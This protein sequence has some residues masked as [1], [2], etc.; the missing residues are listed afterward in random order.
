MI[1]LGWFEVWSEVTLKSD[2]EGSRRNPP[3]IRAPNGVVADGL[4]YWG[5]NNIPW[6]PAKITVPVL[7]VKGEW[8]VDTPA[9]MAQ[10]LFP[11]LTGAPYKRYVEIGEGT[12]TLIM[13]KNRMALFETVQQ[14]FD[15]RYRPG[16]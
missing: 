10:A 6:D 12:H 16:Q 8:D 3:V 1:P 7:L 5:N 9:S 13:E 2:P 4:R 14:F 11:K 15:E